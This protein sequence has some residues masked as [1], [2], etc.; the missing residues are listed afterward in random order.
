M[1]RSRLMSTCCAVLLAGCG[2]TSS[3]S[4]VG[5]RSGEDL[6]DV[7]PGDPGS[8]GSPAAA[9]PGV[10]VKVTLVADALP[11]NVVVDFGEL[12]I[13]DVRLNGSAGQVDERVW[14]PVTLTTPVVFDFPA[15]TGCFDSVRLKYEPLEEWNVGPTGR[16]VTALVKGTVDGTPFQLRSDVYAGADYCQSKGPLCA[17][18][19]RPRRSSSAWSW[20][21]GSTA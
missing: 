16:K 13:R 17:S 19:R 20:A 15:A 4:A 1:S 8:L 18:V 3:D 7:P 11:P 5:D 12:M 21:S 14:T 2:V 6:L 10:R 9:A